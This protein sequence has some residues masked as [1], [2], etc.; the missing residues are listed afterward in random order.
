MLVEGYRK[1]GIDVRTEAPVR[2][3]VKDGEALTVVLEDG[4]RLPCDMVV[5]GAGRVPGHRGPRPRDRAA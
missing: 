3:V 1:A 2:A 5:H 4:T